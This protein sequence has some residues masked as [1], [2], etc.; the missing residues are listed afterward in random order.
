MNKIKVVNKMGVSQIILKSLKGQQV[1]ENEVYA[2]NSNKVGGLLH[3]EI[4]PK[5]ST[6]NLIYNTT[7]FISFGEYLATPLNK[8]RFATILQNILANL[9]AIERSYFNQQYLLMDLNKVMVNPATQHIYFIYVPIQFFESGTTLREFLLSIIQYATFAPGEDTSYVKEYI[10]ILNNGINFSVFDLE[11]Y[12][13][14]LLGQKSKTQQKIVCPVCHS[15]LK[16]TTNYCPACGAKVSGVAESAGKGVYNPLAEA[17][18]AS[19][20][21]PQPVVIPE[22]EPVRKDNTQGLSDG[23]TVLG[24]DPGGTTVLGSEEL[25]DPHYPFLIREKTQEKILLNKPS[26]RIG[27]E[28][29]YCDYFVFDNNA[30]SRSH[31]DIVTREKRYF[32][33]DLNSTNKTYIDGRAIPIE[34]EVEI[35]SGAHI[36]LAN[37]DFVFYIE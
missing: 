35:F 20:V 33:I 5:G 32:I 19:Q 11:E 17:S 30:V 26:F 25:Y 3:L 10:T 1:N 14:T 2:I 15:E 12:I 31:A 37:E 8:E 28:K 18:A 34:C 21:V 24:A 23:T 27:K 4:V 9:K 7:G 16:A 22:P 36:R 13:K 6:F 29:K